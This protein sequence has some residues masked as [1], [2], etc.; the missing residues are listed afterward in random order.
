MGSVAAFLVLEA[1]EHAEARGRKPYARLGPVLSD[2]CARR[3][4]EAAANARKQ[5]EEIRKAAR[6][7]PLAVL[8]GAT[9]L[10][11]P[12]REEREFLGGLIEAGEVGTVRS[13]VNLL[14]SSVEAAFAA[15]VG[16]AA[17]AL[18]RGGFYPPTDDT[19]FEKPRRFP[20]QGNRRHCW[21]VWRGEGMGLVEAIEG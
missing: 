1:R 2:R 15:E 7:K 8:S 3:P 6:H 19:G 16:L 11:G 21:G 10:A 14:G 5:F 18:S 12:T 20:A 17:L 13:V 4:G 9:G